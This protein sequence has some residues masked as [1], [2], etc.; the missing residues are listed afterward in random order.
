[1]KKIIFV[2]SL[3]GLY[4]HKSN[5]IQTNMYWSVFGTKKLKKDSVIQTNQLN[6]ISFQS[7]EDNY[8]CIH[9]NN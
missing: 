9:S 3:V 7:Q 5:E 1:M 8:Y 4:N 6:T 2:L